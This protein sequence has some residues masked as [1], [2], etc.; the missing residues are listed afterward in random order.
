M[1]IDVQAPFQ[2]SEPMQLLIEERINK[3]QTFFERIQSA[4][5]F[6]KDDIQRFNHKDNRTAEIFLEVPGER[7]FAQDSADTF[8]KAISGAAEKMRRQIR[9]YKDLQSPH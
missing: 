8:E 4:T 5:V 3:L 1:K 7:L 9:K 2:V 6:L